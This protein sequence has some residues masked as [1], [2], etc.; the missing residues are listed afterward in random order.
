M[1]NLKGE[2][3]QE[4][5]D[6]VGD[7]E[8]DLRPLCQGL[9]FV[10]TDS[11]HPRLVLKYG[12][13][14]LV[15]D[16]EAC[17]PAC[18]TL[19]FGYYRYDTRHLSQW[20][21]SLEGVPLSLLSHDVEKG[22]AGSFLYTNP[23]LATLAQQK[24][25]IQRQIVLDEIVCEKLVVENFSSEAVSV[26]L[27]IKCQSD[28]ADMFEVRG[29]NRPERG[30]RMVPTSDSKGHCLFLAYK[31]L[32]GCLLETVIEFRGPLPQSIVDGEVKYR[33]DLPVRAQ[34]EIEIYIATRNNGCPP[35]S[36]RPATGFSS[37]LERADS[38]YARWRA[39]GARVSTEHEI[40]NFALDRGLRDI[41][42]LRQSTPRGTGLAAGIPWY[43]A[44][45]GRDSAIAGWQMLP[46]R[47][48]IARECIEVLAAYQGARTDRFR[49]ERSGKI[50][51]ELRLGELA[52][53]N[54]IPHT[55]YYGSVD[56][57]ALWLLLISKYLQW[58]GDLEFISGLWPNIKLALGWLDR[59]TNG[60]YL[61]YKRESPQGLENQGWKDSG[62][63]V[64]H[65]DGQLAKPPIAI[66]EA[67]GYLYAAREAMSQVARILNHNAL[68]EKLQLQASEFKKSFNR[69]FWMVPEE[70]PALALDGDGRQ[71][72]VISSNA[73][74]C[75]WSGI[76]DEPRANRVTDRLLYQ[77]IDSGWGL[78]TLSSE[79][80]FYNPMSYHNGSVWPHDNA[81]ILEGLRKI[82]R[83]RDAHK[84]MWSMMSV[85]QHQQDFR[86]PELFC[87]FE[88]TD[89]SR[90]IDY[91]VS[92]SPQSWSAGSIFQML[93]AC[94]NLQPDA[95]NKTLRILDPSLPDWLEGLTIRNLKVGQA[96][97]DISFNAANGHTY[98]QI[99]KKVGDLR[100]I[101]ET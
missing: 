1:L 50:M 72:K 41:Y 73:G 19:G 26:E 35:L 45:F 4:P 94:V 51:H 78:R 97:V 22:Y 95:I 46:F 20:E 6:I 3:G 39:E 61:T 34:W 37:A 12:S 7:Y 32:D 2:D 44:V 90:P 79:A 96:E 68:A 17:I 65:A 55:P 92:C 76:L 15:L 80:S 81:I 100:V 88:R 5:L 13:H 87:G 18:N 70:F 42:I 85:A 99:L 91:P 49:G 82:G 43:C 57:T 16:G 71:V 75:I 47:P 36:E 74:H 11:A 59:A 56:A 14:F 48:D 93:T 64:C 9:P 69:D 60:G 38:A 86:L 53:L 66:C 62:D 63:S 40:V 25:M 8:V 83:I 21:I 23:Q 28:F 29:L 27:S 58:T 84:L 98:C 52:R 101:I 31:G 10:L 67:Q 77:D 89:W 30:F 24:L 33:L 54:A